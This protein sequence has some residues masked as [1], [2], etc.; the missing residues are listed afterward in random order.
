[1]ETVQLNLPAEVIQ[2][3]NIPY[4]GVRDLQG[5]AVAIDGINFTASIVTLAALKQYAPALAGAIRRWRQ[6]QRAETMTLSVKGDGISLT[7]ELPPNVST[8]QLLDPQFNISYGT[9]M[10]AELVKRYGNAR[11]ALRAYGPMDVGY[12]YADT[13]LAIYTRN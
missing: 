1:M 7:I 10:L 5:I 3:T 4:E 2:D 13:V 8:Q 9:R 11:E 6:H 12:S